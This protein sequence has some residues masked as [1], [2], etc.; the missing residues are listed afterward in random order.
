MQSLA[1]RINTI[2]EGDCLNVLK[3]MLPDSIDFIMTSPPYADQR[4]KTYGGCSTSEYIDWFLPISK[5]LLRVL[6]PTGSFILNIKEKCE[7]YERSTYVLELVLALKRQGWLW[8]EEYIWFKKNPMPNGCQQRFKDAWE[9]CYH[10]SKTKNFQ[11]FK[12]TV[13]V[14]PKESSIKRYERISETDRQ[15]IDS[16]TGSGFSCDWD[17]M[18]R[19]SSESVYPTNVLYIACET[20]NKGHSA[21]YPVALPT[22]FIKVFTKGADIVLDPFCGSGTTCLAAKELGRQYLGIELNANYAK[23]TREAL[24]G[25]RIIDQFLDFNM[26]EVE[27]K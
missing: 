16:A 23:A 17:S 27:R 18:K 21:A 15:H 10:F 20:Q 24:N 11:I 12:D 6:K 3:E 8:I 14:P 9:H 13:K 1:Q 25:Y 4:K 22:W 7:N 19:T 5:E 2:I 26:S